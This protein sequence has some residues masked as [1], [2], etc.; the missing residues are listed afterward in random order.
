LRK[1]GTEGASAQI[2][3]DGR[4]GWGYYSKALDKVIAVFKAQGEKCE[5][6][7]KY[8][9]EVGKNPAYP[10]V[11]PRCAGVLSSGTSV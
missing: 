5:R 3:D 7:W 9:R 1:T 8:D 11:C 4:T 10:T 6:C 2:H